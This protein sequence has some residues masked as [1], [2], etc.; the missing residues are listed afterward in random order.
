MANGKGFPYCG[1]CKHVELASRYC[2][3][4]DVYLPPKGMTICR[5]FEDKQPEFNTPEILEWIKKFIVDGS[6]LYTYSEASPPRKLCAIS[7]LKDDK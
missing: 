2:A 4:H 6:T 5:Y 7:D 3:F 1:V